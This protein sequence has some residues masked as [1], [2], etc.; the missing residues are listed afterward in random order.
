RHHTVLIVDD[1]PAIRGFLYD[2]LSESGFR[3]LAVSSGDEAARL[4]ASGAVIDLVF[5]DVQMPGTLDGY[6]LARWVMDHRPG[7]PVLLASGDLGKANAVQE[8][9][10]AEILPK[11]YD[12]QFVVAKMHAALHVDAKHGA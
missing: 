2:Y 4:L 7:L 8:L 6:G 10:G 11:P 9:C 5:S 3:A 12:F 1:E